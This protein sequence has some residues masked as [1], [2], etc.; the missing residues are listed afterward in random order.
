MSEKDGSVY[1]TGEQQV[2]KGS[3]RKPNVKISG[4][5]S[6]EK[7]VIVGGGS[8]ALGTLEALRENGYKGSI[9]V[10]SSEGYLPFD[11]TKLSKALIDDHSKIA[12]RDE[13]WFKDG[14]VG[15]VSDEVTDVDFAAKKVSTKSGS[16]SMASTLRR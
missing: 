15:V 16:K 2:I 14:S 9:T 5:P 6:P 3:R 4:V 7:V 10:I 8:G 11:R 1:I 13:A 12:L